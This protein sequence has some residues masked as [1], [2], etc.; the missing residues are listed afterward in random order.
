M[1]ARAGALPSP[2]ADVVG[3][4][5]TVATGGHCV[6]T[7]GQ[8]VSLAGHCVSTA[9]HLVSATGHLVRVGGHLVSTAGQNV[10]TAR[11]AVG[12]DGLVVAVFACIVA[13]TRPSQSRAPVPIHARTRNIGPSFLKQ[14]PRL[15]TPA[16]RQGPAARPHQPVIGG[17]VHRVKQFAGRARTRTT[18]YVRLFSLT[19]PKQV[20][21]W[22][23]RRTQTLHEE[24][25][26]LA[27]AL[28]L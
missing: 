10:S 23:A 4:G 9:G 26:P 27:T 16:L 14:S 18:V 20:S 8:R 21:G 3:A 13:G 2:T 22:K 12:C 24:R 7:A 6:L 17:L 28:L 5:H 25:R 1:V 11:H 19:I 15:Q